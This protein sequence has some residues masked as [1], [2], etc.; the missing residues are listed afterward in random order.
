MGVG[1]GNIFGPEFK[2]HRLELRTL[3]DYVRLYGG[4]GP[5]FEPGSRWRYSN[6][7]YILLGAVIEVRLRHGGARERG[8]FSFLSN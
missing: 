2:T 5:E 1:T 8:F 7:G 3:D 4:R 6:Y